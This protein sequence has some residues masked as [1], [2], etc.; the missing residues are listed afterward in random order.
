MRSGHAGAAAARRG[1]PRKQRL[2]ALY[3]QILACIGATAEA[4]P[5]RAGRR[6]KDRAA[7]RP[8]LLAEADLPRGRYRLVLA[9]Q[10]ASFALRST[11][12]PWC[13][14]ANGRWRRTSPC[15]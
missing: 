7:P 14:G 1:A 3:P 8:A 6:E 12:A 5:S 10:P 15:A 9:A 2:P 4:G 11:C 13:P